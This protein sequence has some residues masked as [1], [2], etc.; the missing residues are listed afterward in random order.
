M[1]ESQS[2]GVNISDISGNLQAR[3]VVGRD[4]IGT[5][6][7]LDAAALKDLQL[8]GSRRP[9]RNA[10]FVGRED[11]LKELA[12]RLDADGALV[13]LT[14]YGGLGKTQTAIEFAH[15]SEAQFPGGAFWLRCNAP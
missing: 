1:P 3:D 13:V 10:L 2:G 14:G 6:I 5:Q 8:T 4:Q 12:E 9:P 7:N 15:R 11:T